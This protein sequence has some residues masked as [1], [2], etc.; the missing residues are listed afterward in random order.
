QTQILLGH[1]GVTR[2]NPDYVALEVMDAILGEGV[3]GGFTARIP[4]QLRD[5]QGLAYTVGSS[6]TSSV[7][8]EPGVFVSALGTDPAK[9]KT[10]VASLLKEIRRIRT[11]PVEEKELREAVSYL[12][13]SF[14]FDFQTNT[15]LASYL[16]ATQQYGLGY[17]YRRRFVEEVRKVTR[18]DV[19]RVARKYLD[20]EHYTLV[21]VGPGGGAGN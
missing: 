20:P 1:L 18:E 11:A 8:R 2:L 5:V 16:L 13:H 7:G 12:T 10:A 9:E 14:V 15:Q 6:I 4:Y 17:D 3:G 21:V 19:L